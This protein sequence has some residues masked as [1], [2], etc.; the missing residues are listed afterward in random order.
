MYGGIKMET[1]HHVLGCEGVGVTL[2]RM[3]IKY[4]GRL[5]YDA[6]LLK[7]E[8]SLSEVEEI[9]RALEMHWDSGAL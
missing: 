6:E 7:G 2:P 1:L 3:G 8:V 4:G 5:I 9:S